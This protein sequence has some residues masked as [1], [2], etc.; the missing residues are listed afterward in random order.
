MHLTCAAGHSENVDFLIRWGANP[1]AKDKLGNE[2]MQ[3]TIVRGHYSVV[4]YLQKQ[5]ISLSREAI[6]ELEVQLCALVSRGDLP[7]INKLFACGVSVN[8]GDHLGRSA[9]HIA[10][11]G[12]NVEVVQYLI[13]CRAD[14]NLQDSKGRTAVATAIEA[15]HR[16]V[17][18]ALANAHSPSTANA[19]VDGE[20]AT[21]F[22]DEELRADRRE[23]FDGTTVGAT[24][25]AA[26]GCT[27]GLA[28]LAACGD[29]AAPVTWSGE[30]PRVISLATA[31]HVAVP[32]ALRTPSSPVS[33]CPCLPMLPAPAGED[34]GADDSALSE[35]P[36]PSIA[37]AMMAGRAMDPV[38]KECTSVF[39]SGIAGFTT[40]S[41]QLP[42]PR[43]AALL[44][45]LFARFDSLAAHHGVQRVDIVG[46]AYIAATNLTLHQVRSP[47]PPAPNPTRPTTYHTNPLKSRSESPPRPDPASGWHASLSL[48][49]GGAAAPALPRATL[50]YP[51]GPANHRFS[52]MSRLGGRFGARGGGGAADCPSVLEYFSVHLVCCRL[53]AGPA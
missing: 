14:V 40:I 12:G 20:N 28:D 51:A 1:T 42:A 3:E 38:S 41:D 9:L 33:V 5:G 32:D 23:K 11:S 45:R 24:V 52:G 37:E 53:R 15:R 31:T 4:E 19:I 21:P 13:T 10:S 16:Q 34:V 25:G 29:D 27:A 39:V 6:R 44:R 49:V 48:S 47:H 7:R 43:V 8:S 22:T 46:D 30:C 50:F 36:P 35:A 2:P 17:L 26:E 18:T